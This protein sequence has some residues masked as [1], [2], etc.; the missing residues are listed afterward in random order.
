MTIRSLR[1]RL[2]RLEQDLKPD[3]PVLMLW[4]DGNDR[5]IERQAEKARAAGRQVI[6][7]GWQNSSKPTLM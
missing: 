4:H 3:L 2:D 6:I 1:R 7:V 5:D